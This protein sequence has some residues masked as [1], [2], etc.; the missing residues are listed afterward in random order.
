MLNYIKG[1]IVMIKEKTI[2]IE[3]YNKGYE[4]NFVGNISSLKVNDVV[5]IYVIEVFNEG[6]KY[7]CFLEFSEKEMFE[8][9]IKIKGVG[10]NS[11]TNILSLY[12]SE[13]LKS[14]V[15]LKEIDKL[16]KIP[17]I[18]TKVANNIIDNLGKNIE[19][20]DEELLYVLNHLIPLGFT[21]E[22]I[23]DKYKSLDSDINL[24]KKI[25]LIIKNK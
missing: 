9:L 14:I 21:K 4:Y 12:S 25:M 2:I 1:K 18:G 23:L 17:K 16:K 20:N 8:I 24:D 6:F 7:W 13:E 10:P 19:S 15:N 11:A 5:K 3:S 22:Y